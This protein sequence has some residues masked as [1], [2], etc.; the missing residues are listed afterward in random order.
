MRSALIASRVR[1]GGVANGLPVGVGG[2]RPARAAVSAVPLGTPRRVR[3]EARVVVPERPDPDRLAAEGRRP[4]RRTAPRRRPAA[5]GRTPVV[6]RRRRRGCSDGR[7]ATSA[8]PSDLVSVQH[9]G[10]RRGRGGRARRADVVA[11]LLTRSPGEIGSAP[12]GGESD[13]DEV[14]GGLLGCRTPTIAQAAA[15]K[16]VGGHS[17]VTVPNQ[18]AVSGRGRQGRPA[19]PARLVRPRGPTRRPGH[20]RRATPA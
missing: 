13:R 2:G 11:D 20:R 9:E 1:T 8:G 19:A 15:E 18:P 3:G 16:P 17:V 14:R 7:S 12:T 4:S 6:G 5:R 10:V